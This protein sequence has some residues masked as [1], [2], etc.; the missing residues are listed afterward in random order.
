M[1]KFGITSV[2]AIALGA[3]SLAGSAV[4]VDAQM[5]LDPLTDC[6]LAHLAD[7]MKHPGNDYIVCYYEASQQIC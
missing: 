5:Q 4:P 6:Q 3:P 7:C 2:L 1:K